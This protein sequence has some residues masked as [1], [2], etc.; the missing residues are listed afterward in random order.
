VAGIFIGI[1]A[2]R[3]SGEA[4]NLVRVLAENRR[5]PLLPEISRQYEALKNER[6][7][8][9]EAEIVSAFPMDDRQLQELI[10]ALASRTGKRVKPQVSIDPE[11]IAGVRVAI[12]DKVIDASVRA[13][14][15]A[16]EVALKR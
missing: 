11:L 3:L 1:L 12:G 5:L 13:Q 4:D 16:L 2:G 15:A 14:L 9:V 6:E 10:G 8:T 7:G